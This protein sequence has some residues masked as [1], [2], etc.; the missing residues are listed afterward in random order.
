V[1][2]SLPENLM[3]SAGRTGIDLPLP[4]YQNG[5]CVLLPFC[6]I[7]RG[8]CVVKIETL[9]SVVLPGL[10]PVIHVR[11]VRLPK[12]KITVEYN[13]PTNSLLYNKTSI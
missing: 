8:I 10:T 13:E 7:V 3:A 12:L 11:L 9:F 2:L 4:S 5:W 6:C 1:D